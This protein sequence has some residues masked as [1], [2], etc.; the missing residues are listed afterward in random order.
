MAAHSTDDNIHYHAHGGDER[1]SHRQISRAVAELYAAGHGPILDVGCAQ[2]ML[3]KTLTE[4]LGRPIEI[5][6]I[7]PNA[8]WATKAKPFYREVWPSTVETAPLIQKSYGVVVCGDVLEH[9]ADPVTVLRQ[10]RNAADDDARFIISVPNIAHLSIRLLLLLGK[11]PK[12][13]RGILD[14][15]HLQFLTKETAIDMLRR[16]NLKVEKVMT[17]PVPFDELL[18]RDSG[19]LYRSIMKVQHLSI[20]LFPRLFTM[21]WIFLARPLPNP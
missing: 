1:S 7:E 5:D 19:L 16:A 3:G 10:L 13:E 4:Q 9:L 8:Q 15:T 18:H 20:D 14:K 2:G 17:T 11:F 12:M 21:Q 6:G